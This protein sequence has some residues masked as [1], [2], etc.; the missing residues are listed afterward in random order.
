MTNNNQKSC[1]NYKL[2]CAKFII[3][4]GLSVGVFIFGCVSL[5]T[6]GVSAPLAP[7]YSSMITGA[8]S[9]WVPTPEYANNNVIQIDNKHDINAPINDVNNINTGTSDV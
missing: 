3:S 8:L 1:S 4:A 5:A 2:P 6:G 7:L 9:I